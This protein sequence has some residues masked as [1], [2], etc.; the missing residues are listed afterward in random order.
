MWGREEI[1]WQDRSWRLLENKG[2]VEVD[3]FSAVGAVVGAGMTVVGKGVRGVGWRMAIGGAGL[4]GTL[5]VVGYMGWRYGVKGGKWQEA[6]E[7]V[8]Q[9]VNPVMPVEESKEA[10]EEVKGVREEI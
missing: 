1:E 6:V 10:G 7:K 3:G 5:G 2:Q 8:G 9:E 4:G